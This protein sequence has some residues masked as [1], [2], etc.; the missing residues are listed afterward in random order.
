MT[1]HQN[2][3]IV[4]AFGAGVY[5]FSPTR[6]REQHKPWSKWFLPNLTRNKIHEYAA[7]IK[8]LA[9]KDLIMDT[10]MLLCR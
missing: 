10:V 5:R 6:W 8:I 7:L 3:D 9:K 2:P 4:R 1:D